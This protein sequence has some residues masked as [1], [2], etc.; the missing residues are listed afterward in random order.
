M[1]CRRSVTCTYRS[2]TDY[3]S[4]LKLGNFLW[5]SEFLHLKV[6]RNAGD[7]GRAPLL[8]SLASSA[9]NTIKI[10]LNFSDIIVQTPNNSVDKFPKERCKAAV[11]SYHYL[12]N[13][14]L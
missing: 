12:F 6:Q 7:E 4:K 3:G 1:W 11:S 5:L 10:D 13:I 8:N 2:V 9:D 14:D